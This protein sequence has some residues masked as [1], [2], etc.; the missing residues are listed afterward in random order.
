[1]TSRG[2]FIRFPEE[3]FWPRVQEPNGAI[4]APLFE[5]PSDLQA[6]AVKVRVSFIATRIDLAV[7]FAQ[8]AFLYK[9]MGMLEGYRKYFL[10]AALHHAAAT[11]LLNKSQVLLPAEI[12]RMIHAK[13]LAVSQ[14]I[15]QAN[16]VTSR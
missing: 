12:Q 1:M 13:L 8:A 5:T 16:A 7:A 4:P 9:Q 11:E 2:E 15:L 10:A 6:W 3:H 14:A